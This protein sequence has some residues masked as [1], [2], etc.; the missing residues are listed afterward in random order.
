MSNA[1]RP[2]SRSWRRPVAA[3]T[4]LAVTVLG[5]V[6]AAVVATPAA[7]AERTAALVGS[8]QSELGC[9]GD[10]QPDCAQTELAPT[11]VAGRYAAEF[12]VPAGTYEYKVALNDTWDEAYGGN[13]GGDNTPLVLAGPSTIRFT[14]D[15][16]T[17]R[18]ALTP[19]GLADGYTPADDAVVATPVRDPGA[20]QQFYFVMTD[21]FADGDATNDTGGLTG[22]RLTTGYDPTDKG[23]YEGGDLAG[24]HSK[25]DY[26]QGLG[27]T[28]IWLTPSFKNKPVQGTGADASA[29]YHGYWVT[30]FTQIDPH[31]GTNA[32]LESLIA[33]AH[34]RGIKVYFDIITNHTADVIDYAQQTYGYVDQATSPYKDADGNAFDPHTYAGTDTFPTMD[35]ATSFPYTPVIKPEDAHAKV[36]DW[37]NDPTLYH[38]RGNSTYTG[39]STTYGD[40]SGLDDLMTENPTVV[41][42]FVDVYDAWVDLGV[43]GFRIDTAKHVNF[44]FWQKFTTA[45]QDHAASVGNPDFFMFGEVY[46]A[47]PA[48]LSPYVRKSDMNGVLDFTFQSA[49]SNYAKGSSAAGL[50]ALYAG[51]DMYTTPTTNA[52]ALP[53]FLGNH[54]M[55]RIG[56]MVKDASNPEQRSEL[57]HSLMYLTRGQPVVYYGDEQGFEGNGTLNG[58]DKDARQSMFATQVP[59]YAN[60]QLLDGTTAGSV[61]RYDTDSALY[62][63]I[64]ELGR[65]PREQQGAHRRRA[66]R[67]VCRRGRVRVLP[68]RCDREDRAPRRDEQRDVGGDGDHRHPDAG[69]H[70]RPAVRDDDVRHGGGRRDGLGDRP[71]AGCPRPEGRRDGRSARGRGSAH[72]DRPRS[73]RGPVRAGAGQRRRAD[74]RVEPD[75]VRVP[76]PRRRLLDPAGDLR[77][78]DAAG[79]RRRQRPAGRRARG[80]PRRER[81]RRGPQGR[82]VHVRQRRRR[83]RRRRAAHR[84]R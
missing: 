61:D 18:T 22:D 81:R 3:V 29:G 56:Y 84:S 10:W 37:L 46:D 57:A 25:L 26:I 4:A 63:H 78:D 7:A 65:A 24:L 53:T 32:E 28:A 40:F 59:E 38:N 13:G 52:Q 39:E 15:D 1:D 35:P 67:A 76:R 62:A 74:R 20:G 2:R 33:D 16:T 49:A 69:C 30:D 14:Y 48:K 79:L 55:G 70:V 44:E 68:R 12:T 75:V 51:D 34:A 77:V 8:L 21:R 19:L 45:V 47:D 31:L 73:G 58:T 27:S 71:G 60:Q 36:P 72:G 80:V 11:D 6:G 23:F 17:H 83:G 9:A 43:D 50:H 5:L 41:N 66:D 82:R 64:A 54:D 42:G